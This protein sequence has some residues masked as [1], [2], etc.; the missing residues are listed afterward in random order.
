MRLATLPGIGESKDLALEGEPESEI[1]GLSRT[2]GP[3]SVARRSCMYLRTRTMMTMLYICVKS[4]LHAVSCLRA[5]TMKS[6][7]Q[8]YQEFKCEKGA[9][10]VLRLD[11]EGEKPLRN[12]HPIY[13]I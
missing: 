1:S 10:E 9:E 6:K 7:K 2:F 8:S 11:D 3:P 4:D 12:Q 13:N 5:A